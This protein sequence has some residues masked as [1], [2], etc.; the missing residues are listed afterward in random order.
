MIFVG[1]LIKGI[2]A[3]DI[4]VHNNEEQLKTKDKSSP[5]T[6]IKYPKLD[7]QPD[8]LFTLGSPISGMNVHNNSSCYCPKR[9]KF[10]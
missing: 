3:Y 8:F 5:F 4:V 6:D 7:F 2:I 10:L 1:C 9:L